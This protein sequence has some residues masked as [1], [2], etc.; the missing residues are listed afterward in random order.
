MRAAMTRRM[1]GDGWRS[2]GRPPTRP[3]PHKHNAA[4]ASSTAA[5]SLPNARVA[6]MTSAFGARRDIDPQRRR[7]PALQDEALRAVLLPQHAGVEH[8]PAHPIVVEIEQAVQ[9]R[10]IRNALEGLH[11]HR[12]IRQR[13]RADD[14]EVRGVE[15][16]AG[17]AR[18]A[19]VFAPPGDGVAV[20][21]DD[22]DALPHARP[23][24]RAAWRTSPRAMAAGFAISFAATRSTA[25][26]SCDS[27]RATSRADA[28]H[29]ARQMTGRL[30]IEVASDAAPP[31]PASSARP[32][33][34]AK[35]R[36]P[37]RA[38]RSCGLPVRREAA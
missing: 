32:C 15:L 24:R 21:R 6:S 14:V 2:A 35:E 7:R 29:L 16:V 5:M 33:R 10:L 8:R 17:R 4:S 1:D 26:S 38:R 28:L 12:R 19:K 11:R 13:P 31:S 27:V 36:P 30:R 37:R 23:L 3:T 22:A 9:L 18:R 20:R 25:A 34:R